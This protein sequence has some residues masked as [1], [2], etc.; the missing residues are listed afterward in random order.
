V[1]TSDLTQQQKCVPCECRTV[2]TSNH[3]CSYFA[4]PEGG[5]DIRCRKLATLE[6][7][8]GLYCHSCNDFIHR[9]YGRH[10][11]DFV[12]CICDRHFHDKHSQEVTD[13]IHECGNRRAVSRG[14]QPPFP[15]KEPD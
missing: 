3:C 14:M 6:C 2:V 4:D 5:Y 8:H 13:H 7:E 15:V 1:A 9:T 11:G 10:P 12:C